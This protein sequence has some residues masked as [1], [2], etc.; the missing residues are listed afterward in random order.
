MLQRGPSVVFSDWYSDIG[1]NLF[2]ILPRV[3]CLDEHGSWVRR[4]NVVRIYRL[5]R[6]CIIGKYTDLIWTSGSRVSGGPGDLS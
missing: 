3:F 1:S 6:P 5:L 4:V 2:R